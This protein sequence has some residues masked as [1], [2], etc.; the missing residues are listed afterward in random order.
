MRKNHITHRVI[1]MVGTKKQAI[2]LETMAAIMDV[3]ADQTNYPLLIHCN[4]GK[5]C[6]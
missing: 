5:V 1:N 6:F 4:H 3:V 2:P